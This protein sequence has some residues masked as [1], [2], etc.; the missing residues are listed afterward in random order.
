MTVVVGLLLVALG[1]LVGAAMAFLFDRYMRWVRRHQR[2]PLVRVWRALFLVALVVVSV[3]TIQAA[4]VSA[5][6]AADTNPRGLVLLGLFVGFFGT[7]LV[8]WLRHRRRPP[9]KDGTS[10]TGPPEPEWPTAEDMRK[11]QIA[12]RRMKILAFALLIPILAALFYAAYNTA[13][14]V[15]STALLLGVIVVGVGVWQFISRR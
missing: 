15:V 3:A 11:S 13:S 6:S 8:Y 10:V 7:P 12:L 4:G 2:A 5:T 9:R 1:L 14:P